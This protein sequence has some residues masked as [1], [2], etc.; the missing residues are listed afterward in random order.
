[1]KG[2]FAEDNQ[3]FMTCRG[4]ETGLRNY[5]KQNIERFLP[6]LTETKKYVKSTYTDN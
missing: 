4:K 2:D 1:V 3:V 6:C 5:L